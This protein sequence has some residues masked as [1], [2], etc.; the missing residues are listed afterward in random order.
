MS[1]NNVGVV[2]DPASPYILVTGVL[3]CPIPRVSV[4]G[5]PKLLILRPFE[6]PMLVPLSWRY[7]T[8]PHWTYKLSSEFRLKS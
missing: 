3:E 8:S 1:Y 5:P 4:H 2:R 6:K 7:L